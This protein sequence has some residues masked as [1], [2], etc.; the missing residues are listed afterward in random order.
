MRAQGLAKA[1]DGSLTGQL[2]LAGDLLSRGDCR[3]V[4]GHFV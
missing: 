4:V 2:G 1:V 3:G